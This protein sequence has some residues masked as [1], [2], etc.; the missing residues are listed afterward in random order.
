M[1]NNIEENTY[2][3]APINIDMPCKDVNLKEPIINFSAKTKTGLSLL[4]KTI[5]E[6]FINKEIDFNNEI[7][8]SNERQ[9]SLIKKAKE[10]ISNVINAISDNLPE[11]FFTIDL[12]DAYTNLSYVLGIEINDDLVDEIFSKFCMGK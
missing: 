8:I 12:N 5:E 3:S 7:F 2:I 9:L 11:D 10:S 6:M 4:T 1:K